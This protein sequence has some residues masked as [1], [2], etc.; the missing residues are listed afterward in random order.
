MNRARLQEKLQKQKKEASVMEKLDAIRA[1]L[2]TSEFS[3]ALLLTYMEAID[4]YHNRSLS[5][6]LVESS[7]L[8]S[9]FLGSLD[10]FTNFQAKFNEIVKKKKSSKK[11]KKKKRE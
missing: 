5:K 1:K 4:K 6:P 2:E 10:D 3:P 11:K 8:H 7:P 9:P